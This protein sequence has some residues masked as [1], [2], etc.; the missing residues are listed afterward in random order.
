MRPRHARIDAVG[1][2]PNQKMLYSGVIIGVLLNHCIAGGQGQ[3]L[4]WERRFSS[5]MFAMKS[6]LML[7]STIEELIKR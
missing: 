6:G 5:W 1:P 7:R 4:G 2:N 3:S